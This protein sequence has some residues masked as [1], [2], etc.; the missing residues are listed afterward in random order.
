MANV[1]V[2]FH[3]QLL[4]YL[5]YGIDGATST[6]DYLM[7]LV[8]AFIPRTPAHITM[9]HQQPVWYFCSGL[10]SVIPARI[11]FG[12]SNLIMPNPPNPV[13][14]PTE[15]HALK[16]MRTIVYGIYT[17]RHLIP[18]LK[19]LSHTPVVDDLLKVSAALPKTL[20]LPA[21]AYAHL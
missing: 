8:G 16:L 2:P 21:V 4:E 13:V 5:C 1:K 14:H 17:Y 20:N 18:A 10:L 6:T 12:L 11:C 15:Y 19:L 7:M 9:L 3:Q